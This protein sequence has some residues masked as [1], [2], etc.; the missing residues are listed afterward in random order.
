V[1]LELGLM[2]VLVVSGGERP[3]AVRPIP[4]SIGRLRLGAGDFDRLL[5][6]VYRRQQQRGWI[7]VERRRECGQLVEVDTA[8][9][10]FHLGDGVGRDI[11]PGD[12]FRQLLEAEPLLLADA[13]EVAGCVMSRRTEVYRS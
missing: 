7:H 6:V 10:G 2:G 5:P 13:V 3:V 8:L 4:H 11:D 1:E 9:P 12:P